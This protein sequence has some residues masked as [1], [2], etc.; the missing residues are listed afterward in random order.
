MILR[1]SRRGRFVYT[2]L[3]MLKKP[4]SSPLSRFHCPMSLLGR[5][6]AVALTLTAT[7]PV[8]AQEIGET[9]VLKWK[10]GKQAVFLLAFDD[11]CPTHLKN[12]IPELEKRGMVG[13]F[14]VNP[15]KGTYPP[16]KAEWEKLAKGPVVVL[17]NHTFTHGGANDAAQLDG[18][19][20]KC[21]DALKEANPERK[22]PRLIAFGKPGGVP[23]KV[24][25]EEL[26]EALKKHHLVD[27]PP[28]WG[29]PIHQKS[30]AECVATIDKA[31]EKGD[32]GHLDFHGVGGDW[33]T[34]P[35]DWFTAI[36]DKLDAEKE[37]IWVTDVVSYHQYK[38]QRDG[39]EVKVLQTVPKGIR[40][41]LNT[42]A[43][44]AFYDHPLTLETKVP[45]DWKECTVKQGGSETTVPITAGVVRYSALPGTEEIRLL[46]K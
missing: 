45:A 39:A 37:R 38:T 2:I 20:Q 29:P 5:V 32:M 16:K 21:N 33:L 30:A 11:A 22:W 15:G 13:N 1:K 27:R 9:K 12:V 8:I 24:T 28:F 44:P 42:N 23:W 26:D 14:Y 18:E 17:A 4:T 19:L 36:M 3:R 40:L 6:A 35:L 7:L 34:T 10:D 25:K 46:A 31:L 43:D 41:T